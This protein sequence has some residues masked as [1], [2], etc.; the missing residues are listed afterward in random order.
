M[1]VQI[2]TLKADIA[3]DLRAISEI[4]SCL[5]GYSDVTG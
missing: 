4:Y 1:N 3:A 2:R 5:D